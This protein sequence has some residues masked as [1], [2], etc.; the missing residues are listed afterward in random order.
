VRLVQT[1]KQSTAAAALAALLWLNC[2][3]NVMPDVGLEIA[4]TEGTVA[5]LQGVPVGAGNMWE[6]DY[7]LADKTHRRGPSAMLFIKGE[8]PTVVGEGSIVSVGGVKWIV[9]GVTLGKP[10]GEVRLAPLR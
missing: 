6:R 8:S 3:D 4:I 9:L 5:P 10:R 7:E 2:G 1:A